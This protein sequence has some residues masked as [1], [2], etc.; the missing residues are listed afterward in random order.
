MQVHTQAH[1]CASFICFM[2]FP[3]SNHSLIF[4]FFSLG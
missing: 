1:T 4:T 3:E 2:I